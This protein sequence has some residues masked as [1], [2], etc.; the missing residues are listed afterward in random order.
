MRMRDFRENCE[1]ISRKYR[2]FCK[3][4]LNRNVKEKLRIFNLNFTSKERQGKL[5]EV[6]APVFSSIHFEPQL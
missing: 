1:N 3:S 5:W 2:D 6:K 4:I